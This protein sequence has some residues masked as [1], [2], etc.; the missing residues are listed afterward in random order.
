MKLEFSRQNVQKYSNIKSLENPPSGSR[1]V[2]CGRTDGR[3]G[4][5]KLSRYS[6]FC[7]GAKKVIVIFYPMVP[8]FRKGIAFW[9]VPRLGAFVLPVRTTCIRRWVWITG[10]MILTGG[11]W[12]ARR[13][14][15]PNATFST[16]NLI[17]N[18]LGSNPHLRG[19]RPATNCL[20]SGTARI[21]KLTSI[22]PKSLAR[23]A[24]KT[25]AVSFIKTSQLVL[26]TE[27]N[28]VCS[29]ILTFHIPPVLRKEKQYRCHSARH[30]STWRLEV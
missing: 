11:N 18:D 24:Q 28:A 27:I 14:T 2:S 7:E 9:K 22:R 16:S 6:K 10:G 5:M 23:T 17:P 8:D 21:R 15:C 26:Y 3:T 29:Q 20:N 25:L 19:D 1:V 4:M 30:E 13:K 12:S